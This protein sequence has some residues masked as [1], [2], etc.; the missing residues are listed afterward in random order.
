MSES[1]QNRNPVR[2]RSAMRSVGQTLGRTV[3]RIARRP[4]RL[5]GRWAFSLLE[6]TLVVLI[7]G[8]V[9]AMVIPRFG[10]SIT[11][12]SADGAARRIAAD[13]RLVRRY[14]MMTSAS[15][16]FRTDATGYELL[17]MSHPDHPSQPY[18]VRLQ[19]DCHGAAWQSVDAGGDADLIFDMYGAPDS[20]ATFIV[21]V[22]D[23][24]RTIIVAQESGQVEI[25]E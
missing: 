6:L 15:Q 7:I 8:I 13:L 18:R 14:A 24:T 16:T 10:N 11:R 12:H 4:S 20:A 1:G 19:Q 23:Q 22:A 2:R 25:S 5:A 3:R 17:G 9:S 21:R